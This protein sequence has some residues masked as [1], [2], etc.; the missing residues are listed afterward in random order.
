[1]HYEDATRLIDR[2]DHTVAAALLTEE[3]LAKAEHAVHSW[4][5][6]TALAEARDVLRA[7]RGKL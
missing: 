2:A 3:M 6:S 1:M 7:L 4:P 5:D